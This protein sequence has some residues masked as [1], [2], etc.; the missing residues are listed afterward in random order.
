MREAERFGIDGVPAF[1]INGTL[2]SGAWPLEEFSKV[3]D[4]AL[5]VLAQ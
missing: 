1:I 3:I 2:L 5:A 4:E